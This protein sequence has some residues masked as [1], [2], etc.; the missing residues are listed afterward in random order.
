VVSNTL[1]G[2]KNSC[3]VTEMDSNKC[4]SVEF[5][6][7]SVFKMFLMFYSNILP[8]TLRSLNY[9][10]VDAELIQWKRGLDCVGWFEGAGP[11]RPAEGEREDRTWVEPVGG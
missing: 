6:H 4:L 3:S 1:V 2:N 9:M 10:Q 11:V 7:C 5:L 8:Q